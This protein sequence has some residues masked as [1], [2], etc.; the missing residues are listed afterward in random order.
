[1]FTDENCNTLDDGFF[2]PLDPTTSSINN[3][4]INANQWF[5][6][7]GS[8]HDKDG[9]TIGFADGHCE[10]HKWLTGNVCVLPAEPDPLLWKSNP[11]NIGTKFVDFNWVIN[12]CSAPYP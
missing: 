10:F 8:Y 6:L 9:D 11:V 4:K 2:M 12:H 1:M 7:P 5:N 3:G